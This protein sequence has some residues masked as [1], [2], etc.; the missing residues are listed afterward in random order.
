MAGQ[1]GKAVGQLVNVMTDDFNNNQDG[2]SPESKT[3]TLN[4]TKTSF[5]SKATFNEDLVLPTLN[6][7]MNNSSKPNSKYN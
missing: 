4:S 5:T 6:S 2:D 3:P 7:I 1:V